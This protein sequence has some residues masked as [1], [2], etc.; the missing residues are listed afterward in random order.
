MA[1]PPGD[2]IAAAFAP[3]SIAI[4]GASENPEKIGGRPIRY[5]RS[6][7]YAGTLYPINPGRPTV[8]GLRA[9]PDLASLPEA[10]ELAVV[11]VPGGQ[12][13][14]AVRDCARAGVRVAV[15]ISSGFGETGEAGMAAQREMLAAARTAGM[16]LVGPNT[17]GIVNFGNATIASFATVIGEVAPATGPVAIVSQ[18]GAMS[19]VPYVFLREE[20][21]GIRHAHATGNEADL[22]VA[23]FAHAVL[24][25]PEVR[26]VLLYLESI[27]DAGALA[28]AAEAALERDVPVV[29][30]KAGVSARGSAAAS[31]HTGAV[32]TEDRVVDAFFR[33]HG[34]QRVQDMRALSRAARGY[35][36]GWRP[37]GRRLVAISNSGAC[38]VMAADSAARHGLA[39][40]PLGAAVQARLDTVLPA[41]AGTSNPIDLTA[42]LL[43]D[44][45][46]LSRVLPIV[47]AGGE[48]DAVF[49]GL[50]MSGKGYDSP[51]FARDTAAFVAASGLPVAMAAPLAP[52]R[53]AFEA[54]G[55]PAWAHDEDAIAS[56]AQVVAHREAMDEAQR[57]APLRAAA[58]ADA[59]TRDAEAVRSA[60][61]AAAVRM[62][63]EA[64]ALDAADRPV[65]CRLAGTRRFFSEARSLEALAAVGV[66]VTEFSLCRDA[67]DVRRAVARFPG[68]LAVKACSALLPHKSEHGLV[69]LG[70]RGEASALEAFEALRATAG[71]LGVALDG[72]IV[73]PMAA[74]Q[75]ELVLGARYDAVFGAVVMV[76]DGGKYV[77][78]M[79][80]VATLVHPFDERCV[81]DRLAG[82][83]AAPVFAGVRG[84][85]PLPLAALARA[86]CALGDWVARECG[87][88]ASVD[89]NPLMA[90]PGERLVAVDA[91]VEVAD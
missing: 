53:Q 61:D 35:L 65:A 22:T 36:A 19:L 41:F 71:R 23:D 81:L 88:I 55:V 73:A 9:W 43:A 33:Q 32:A 16:R 13:V 1:R 80:D 75:R 4:I 77:E 27:A 49:I 21:V 68:P 70:C 15:V 14:Q 48:A 28:R 57:L 38:G 42:M 25:D 91:L 76:G 62:A 64:R 58:S 29:A 24:R 90:G 3:R 6:L 56:L 37:R 7:G 89:V 59:R 74:A 51:S 17:Q 60:G 72:V 2:W 44:N 45:S 47:G 8:Q 86:A 78:A 46:L 12:A 52:T 40:Q 18:S 30:L 34:I 63:G 83:R 39:M 31:S 69:R 84:E 82:L 66:P 5:M 67:A 10:P 20:G 11:C 50:P 79:P 87:R 85:S 54:Q 26:L